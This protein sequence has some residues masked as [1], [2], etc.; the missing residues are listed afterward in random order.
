MPESTHTRYS[1]CAEVPYP[2]VTYHIL[3]H[4]R[5]NIYMVLYPQ[6]LQKSK[7]HAMMCIFYTRAAG[8]SLVRTLRVL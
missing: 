6:I 5:V 8:C 7:I 4:S 1:I 3:Q 2:G